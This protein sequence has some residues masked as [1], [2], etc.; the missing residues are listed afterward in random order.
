MSFYNTF[1][2]LC[3]K[4]DIKPTAAVKEIGI[5]GPAVNRWKNG[6]MPNDV[7]LMKIANYFDVSMEYLKTGQEPETKKDQPV[8]NADKL[9]DSR[10][11]QQLID[12]LDSLSE[13]KIAALLTI[14]QSD[15][16]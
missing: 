12:Y 6:S 8:G 11:K 1:L 14:I 3:I 5:T 7:T 13:E 10:V 9:D 15:E 16:K 4:K 2:N